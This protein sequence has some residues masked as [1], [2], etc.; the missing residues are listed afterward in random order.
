MQPLHSCVRFCCIVVWL[1][2]NTSSYAGQLKI[3]LTTVDTMPG[4]DQVT[5]FGINA[6]GDISGTMF[7]SQYAAS[8]GFLWHKASNTYTLFDPEGAQV[9]NGRGLNDAGVVVGDSTLDPFSGVY[10]GFIYDSATGTTTL[11]P[12]ASLR[13]ISNAGDLTG[14]VEVG[15]DQAVAYRLWQGHA[16][17]FSCFGAPY[18]FG[19]GINVQGD[20]VGI[21]LANGYEGGFLYRD[22]TCIDISVP[23]SFRTDIWGINDRG[24]IVGQYS[25]KYQGPNATCFAG[26]VFMH[27]GQTDLTQIPC[28]HTVQS[29]LYAKAPA[30]GVTVLNAINNDRVVAGNRYQATDPIHGMFYGTI[31]H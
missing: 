19:E 20:V 5:P 26:A 23:G 11:Y 29:F 3:D 25:G 14:V 30:E 24:D 17:T 10:T 28:E 31:K 22:G 18:T 13:G 15:S 12:D 1:T 21:Y 27:D 16:E 8:V 2:F 6:N 4:S 7:L 9:T